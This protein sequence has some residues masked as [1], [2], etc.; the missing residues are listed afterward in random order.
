DVDALEDRADDEAHEQVDAGPHHA[1]DHVHEIE[2]PAVLA[3]DGG[4]HHADRDD[5]VAEVVPADDGRRSFGGDRCHDTFL[6]P[7]Y[8]IRK[9]ARPVTSPR[10]TRAWIASASAS[11]RMSVTSGHTAR[12]ATR[13]NVARISARVTYRLPITSRSSSSMS[14]AGT[15][16]GWGAPPSTTSRAP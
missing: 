16:N 7:S 3:H 6:T 1:A 15:L 12:R 4:D 13:S 10:S 9:A 2:E 11:G 5:G 8:A 14:R